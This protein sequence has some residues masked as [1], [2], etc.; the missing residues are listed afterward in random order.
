[1][2]VDFARVVQR[3]V[4]LR[5]TGRIA[6][7]D[8][9]CRNRGPSPLS[10]SRTTVNRLVPNGKLPHRATRLT[11]VGPTVGDE[12][13]TRKRFT[14][15]GSSDILDVGNPRHGS[16]VYVTFVADHAAG[17]DLRADGKQVVAEVSGE[18][19]ARGDVSLTA[20]CEANQ[21]PPLARVAIGA[22]NAKNPAPNIGAGFV[23]EQLV[24]EL[25]DQ[26]AQ[27]RCHLRLSYESLW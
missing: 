9:L 14:V 18:N 11:P 26:R 17:A 6:C 15:P 20:D 4:V 8:R 22:G 12:G 1:M 16:S 7:H 19:Q 13:A 3:P 25:R 21:E 5:R 10:Q 23:G 24:L 2:M 27:V